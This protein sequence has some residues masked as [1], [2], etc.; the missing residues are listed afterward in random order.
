MVENGL[1]SVSVEDATLPAKLTGPTWVEVVVGNDTYPRFQVAAQLYALRAA[2]AEGL[3]GAPVAETMPGEGQVL[4]FAAGKW[5]PATPPAPPTGMGGGGATGPRG[6]EGPAGPAGPPGAPGAAGARGPAG[7]AG[8]FSGSFDGTAT[9]N[10]TAALKGGID[11]SSRVTATVAM[12]GTDFVARTLAGTNVCA[13]GAHPCTAW[14]IMVLDVLSTT[15]LSDAAGWVVGSFPN[16]DEHMRSLANGQNSTVC[17]A[18][19]Y[20]Q[21]YPSAFTH[22]G[23]TTP[24]GLHCTPE[25]ASLPVLCCRNG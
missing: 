17:P 22:G 4:T 16:L 3:Q 9:F 12:T 18:G 14:E 19:L 1:F 11:L 24:G 25:G 10:G 2:T 15:A 7:P 5:G 8:T 13:M 6:P 23:I 21:K 20:L